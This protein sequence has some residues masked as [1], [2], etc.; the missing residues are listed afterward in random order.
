[1]DHASLLLLGGHSVTLVASICL[2][3]LLCLHLWLLANDIEHRV[4]E[5]FLV[6]AESVLLPSEVHHSV[7]E[8][9]PAHAVLEEVHTRVVVRSLLEAQRAAVFHKLKKFGWV[10]SAEVFERS[11]DLLLF[12]VVILFILGATWEALP[13]ELSHD[14]VEKHVTDGFEIVTS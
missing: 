2:L 13:R 10:A 9:V 7:V 1:M 14:E 5:S 12:D 11:L 4:L 3:L 8:V 6:L